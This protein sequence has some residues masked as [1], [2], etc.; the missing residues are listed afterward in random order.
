MDNRIQHP[1]E[2]AAAAASLRY[3]NDGEAGFSRHRSGKG[4]RYKNA[5]G[6]WLTEAAVIHRID[7]LAIPPAW[8]DVW[9]CRDAK[10]H[11]QATGRDQRGRKQY[12]YHPKWSENRG[13]AKFASLAS[14]AKALPRLRKRINRDLGRLGLPRD[15]VLAAIVWLLDN[16]MIRIGNAMYARD[17]GSFGLTTLRNRHVEIEGSKLKFAF[18]GKSGRE[19]LV[20]LSDR[21]MSRVIR[22]IQELPGQSLFQYVGD[23]GQRTAVN[24]DEVNDYIREAACGPFSSKDFRTWGGTVRALT[25]FADRSLPAGKRAAALVSNEVIDQ[26]ALRLGN[27]R[28]VCRKG[29]I[30]PGVIQSWS[31]GKLQSQLG[32][33]RTRG[34]KWMDPEEAIAGKWLARNEGH[35]AR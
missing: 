28:A 23:N 19:W 24:S 3:V 20:K 6:Q 16:A 4:F 2:D 22:Q 32:S 12:R 15:K 13:Q 25:L 26:V 5:S 18:K 9:I 10:G 14:F 31:A 35:P 11:I 34:N 21:R 29:Y 8:T 30:H 33:I 7:T 17:N 1:R 27:T